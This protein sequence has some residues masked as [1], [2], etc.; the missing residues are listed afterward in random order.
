MSEDSV[1][2][3][4][5]RILDLLIYLDDFEL[6]TVETWICSNS[7][8]KDLEIKKQMK[9]SEKCL[10]DIGE[11]IKKIIPF[12]AEMPSENIVP[13]TVGDQADCNAINT[14]HVDE[15]LYDQDEV[16]ELVKKGKL[17]KY[18]CLNCN[19]RNIKDLTLISHSMSRYVL[20]YIFQV[21]LPK[22]LEDKQL[23]D[24]GSRLGAVLYG[25]YY[26]SNAGTIIGI[27]M[28][29]ECCDVQERIISQY[30][31]DTDRIKVINSDVMDRSDIVRNTNVI[32]IN[33]LDF[34]VDI[35][36]HK[37]IWYYFKKYIKKGSYL[38]CNRSM[39]ET[40][41]YLD[42]FEEFMDWLSICKPSQ[43]ENEVFFD[44]EECNELFLYT[45]N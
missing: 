35:E 33:V 29:K 13:P 23:L 10:I 8:K 2:S 26:F 9:K 14:V 32:I 4:K 44:L 12:E 18:Y 1:L 19:S 16:N 15:F 40:L 6:D 42:M 3:A 5:N 28:N 34:F 31:L 45:V 37:Q 7:F 21:L 43:L 11:T 22:D 36:K 27:E 41:G 24:V 30:S 38:V 20:Q 39:A 17:Q 25:A